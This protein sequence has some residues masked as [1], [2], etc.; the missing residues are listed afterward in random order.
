[1]T[2]ATQASTVP[3][4]QSKAEEVVNAITHGLGIP[5]SIAALVVLVVQAV[6][7]SAWHVV[8]VSIFGGSMILLYMAS[9]VY[10]AVCAY[11]PNRVFQILDH[12]FIF[13]LIA[14]TYTP[15]L[16]CCLRGPFGW[17]F[18][19]IVWGMAIGG[20]V[21]KALVLPK[22]EKSTSVIYLIMGWLSVFA[23]F[24]LIAKVPTTGLV[25]LAVGGLLYTIG[26]IF[27]VLDRIR[28]NHAVWH[29]FVLGGSLSHVLAVFY[30]VVP[31]AG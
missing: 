4:R 7:H 15:F 26:V 5:M 22:H 24:E 18:F 16:L 17:T 3:H 30:G 8:S 21:M 2:A 12:A 31:N 11:K 14:G 29:L 23:V 13:V 20:I 10:H 27:F 19:A 6:H 28:F 9:C 1:M 25:W